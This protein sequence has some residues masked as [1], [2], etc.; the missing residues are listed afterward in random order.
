MDCILVN[1]TF[2]MKL[3]NIFLLCL[4]CSCSRNATIVSK[5]S[6][7][8]K[9]DRARIEKLLSHLVW[10][11]TF[12]YVLFGSK[13]MAVCNQ[14]KIGSPYYLTV[15]Q[16]PAYELESLWETWEK[17][18]HLFP[19]SEFIFLTTGNDKI[20]ELY[21]LNKSNCLKIIEN[22]LSLFQKKTS[23]NLNAI[24]M[25]DYIVKSAGNDIYKNSLKKSQGL[26]GI[27]LGFGTENSIDFENY[28]YLNK[29]RG[30]LPPETGKHIDIEDP[31]LPPIPF[32]ASF[33]AE[34]TK[35]LIAD[36]QQERKE[37]LK[38]YSNKNFLET[39]INQL[40]IQ[41]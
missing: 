16:S 31:L 9:E 38:I 26:Y 41:R 25:F 20:F 29:T 2:F 10:G 36:Y 12:A 4:M 3:I 7:I 22:N 11:E 37:I 32:F 5:L 13:P 40:T 30:P 15:H 8:P 17:Y 1:N 33:S 19:M 23:C 6:Q 18:A 14:D 39:T 24:E 35:K 21:L 34:E 28:F 27:L